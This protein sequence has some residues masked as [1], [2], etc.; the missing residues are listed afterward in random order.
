M[1]YTTRSTCRVCGSSQLTHLFSLGEQFVSDFPEDPYQGQKCPIDLELCGDCTLVQLK[2]TAPQD[3]LYTRHYWYVS[4]RT[5]TM[6]DA[7][8]DVA[9]AAAQYVDLQPGDIALDIGSN[10]GCLLRSYNIENLVTVGVEPATNLAEEGRRGVTVFI[11]DFW[12]AR[13][14]WQPFEED[15]GS[16]RYSKPGEVPFAKAITACGMFYDLENPNQFITDVAAVLAPDGVFIAQLMCLRNMLALGDLGNFAHE[17]LEF[18]SLRSLD[19]L[20][21]EHGLRIVGL[22]TNQVNGESYRLYV[23]HER[24]ERVA[25]YRLAKN[26]AE[27]REDEDRRE[28]A[29]PETYRLFYER[30]DDCR[31]RLMSFIR[32]VVA[33]GKK[34]YV[35]GA[36]TK[37]NVISQF[38][39]LDNTLITAAAERSSEKVGRYMVGTGIPIVSEDEF[40]KASPEFALVLP[41]AF[42][43]EMRERELPWLERGGKFIVPLPTPYLLGAGERFWAKSPL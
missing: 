6:R 14:F 17:H 35:Y 1:G 26:L 28:L 10:D 8:L 11:N 12:S 31:R 29:N 9:R 38:L 42:I 4:S 15:I 32:G 16:H 18:Y 40:R 41:Y 3:F 34:V 30:L 27:A 25:D 5:Q 36:S 23:Q 20:F 37:G 39:S 13:A 43:N 33:E 22:E 19:R 7:L 21:G 24:C 2:H